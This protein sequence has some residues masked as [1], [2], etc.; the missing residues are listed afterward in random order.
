M[1]KT[2]SIII[3]VVALAAILWWFWPQNIVAPVITQTHPDITVTT[4]I[5]NA[6]LTSPFTVSGKAKGTWYFEASFPLI[7]QDANGKVLAQLPV[8]AQ[9]DWMTTDFV[10]FSA[11]IAF[12]KPETATGVLILKNDNPSGLPENDKSISIPV[13]FK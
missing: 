10:P 2:I 1:Q 11:S 7:L 4:P 3:A 8:Q 6:V 9:G 13:T 12:A 5:A